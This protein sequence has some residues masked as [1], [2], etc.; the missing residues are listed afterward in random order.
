[1]SDT[2]S[3]I[4]DYYLATQILFL[5]GKVFVDQSV[6]LWVTALPSIIL[7]LLYIVLVL[8]GLVLTAF[9]RS[10]GCDV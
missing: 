4:L 6:P 2:T 8:L 7:I 1:M 9:G 5:F 3:A 10:V